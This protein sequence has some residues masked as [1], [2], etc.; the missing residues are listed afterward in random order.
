MKRKGKKGGPRHINVSWAVCKFFYISFYVNLLTGFLILRL[1]EMTHTASYVK[2]KE[3]K[4]GP[5]H[6][7]VSWAICKFFYLFFYFNLLT[8]FLYL[9]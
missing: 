4:D 2:E 6:V 1:G 9:D 3:N 5:R 8:G 7:N